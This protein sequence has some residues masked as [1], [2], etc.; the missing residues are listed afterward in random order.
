MAS[1]ELKRRERVELKELDTQK[2][3]KFENSTSKTAIEEKFLQA[4]CT[5][6]YQNLLEIN[7]II[8]RRD[9]I[10][11][12]DRGLKGRE[13]QA[14]DGGRGRKRSPGSESNETASARSL[15][16]GQGDQV[17]EVG[18]DGSIVLKSEVERPPEERSESSSGSD[19][20]QQQ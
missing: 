6:T 15:K 8:R 16:S 12:I 10:K 14:K 9:I 13:H 11:N 5:E 17:V 4:M 3:R 1:D 2:L 18:I 7:Q 19:L 20:E